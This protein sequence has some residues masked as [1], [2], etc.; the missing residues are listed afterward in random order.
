MRQPRI[1][2]DRI[3]HAKLCRGCGT[4][5]RPTG[6]YV[7][8]YPFN[9]PTTPR[10]LCDR[11]VVEMRTMNMDVIAVEPAAGLPSEPRP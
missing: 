10:H 11:C 2:K 7:I 8:G 4:R 3:G 1:R 5:R 6:R 9:Q